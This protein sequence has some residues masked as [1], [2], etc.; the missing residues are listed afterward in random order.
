MLSP[1][2]IGTLIG[3]ALMGVVVC[4]PAIASALRSLA[5]ATKTA[6]LGGAT[7]ALGRNAPAVHSAGHRPGRLAVLP[8]RV[9][10]RGRRRDVGGDR[11]GDRHALAGRRRADR[12]PGHRHDRHVAHVRHGPDQRHA[13][14]VP[15]QR[16]RRGGHGRRRRRLRGDRPGGRHDAGPQDRLHARRQAGQAADRPVRLHV[17]GGADRHRRDLRAL[18]Q[19]ARRTRR[20]RRRNRLCP[21][22][23]PPS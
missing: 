4:F 13:H 9:S 19:R 18:V 14:D 5:G 20:L 23:R 22:R 1:L 10:D 15:L 6:G 8:R 2:G 16:Q 17:A 11:H 12:R 7:G 21:P 3:G